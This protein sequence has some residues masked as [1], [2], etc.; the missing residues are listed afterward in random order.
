MVLRT[1]VET[2][3]EA[4]EFCPQVVL[5]FNYPEDFLWETRKPA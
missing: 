5:W 3:V 4:T 1:V 2:K